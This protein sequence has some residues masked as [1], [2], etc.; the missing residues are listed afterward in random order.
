MEAVVTDLDGT[1]IRADGTVSELTLHAARALRDR[2][3][4]LIAATARTPFGVEALPTL[5]PVLT[6]AVCCSGAVGYAPGSRDLPRADW[7]PGADRLP[8]DLPRADW[9][10]GA[11]RLPR[12]LLWADR[13]PRDLVADLVAHLGAG[14]GLA[15]FDGRG[16]AMTATYT[17]IRGGGHRGPQAVVAQRALL[18]VDACSMV[19]C[20]PELT[21]P[22]IVAALRGEGF[23]P[24]R[25]TLTYAE[26]RF[27]Q[28]T[29]PAVD[30][31]SGVLRA[32]RAAGAAPEHTIAF[33]DM[34]I[35]VAMFAVVGHSVAM[36]DAP[37]EV[38]AAATLRTGSVEDDGFAH[39]LV[40]LG[41][42]PGPA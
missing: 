32:L 8:R 22:E 10:P 37:A 23:G 31:A 4:P 17:A 12:D 28:A 27:V 7:L 6:S 21:A 40:R 18:E 25:V 26:H 2:G 38:L 30:K 19:I 14:A 13:L 35:D 24:G 42:V 34:P 33:G 16:W 20:H 3:V 9:L 36:A 11:D 15:L 1:V 41:V 29:A 39:A 5:A